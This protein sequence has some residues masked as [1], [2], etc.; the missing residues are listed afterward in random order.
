MTLGQVAHGDPLCLECQI[1]N[2]SHLSYMAVRHKLNLVHIWHKWNIKDHG[3]LVVTRLYVTVNEP[4]LAITMYKRLKMY[5]D[6]IRLVKQ[7]H[8]D[9]VPDTHVHLAK[10]GLHST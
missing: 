8:Q 6:M 10:V 2:Y 1:R 5:A 9:L 7:Y 3:P 4:D